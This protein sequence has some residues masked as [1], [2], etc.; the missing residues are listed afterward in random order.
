MFRTPSGNNAISV[1][2]WAQLPQ[3]FSMPRRPI[4]RGM[5]RKRHRC[6]A[7]DFR[8]LDKTDGAFSFEKFLKFRGIW[9]RKMN[10]LIFT[11]YN[12]SCLKKSRKIYAVTSVPI[13]ISFRK[14]IF[15]KERN[16]RSCGSTIFHHGA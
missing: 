1:S 7:D 9:Y 2:K 4:L 11:I 13:Q 3:L 5:L 8:S 12:K 15:L 14:N 16:S 6:Q 10:R